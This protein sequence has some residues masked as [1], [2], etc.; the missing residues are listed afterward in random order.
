MQ[1]RSDNA[2]M[3]SLFYMHSMSTG[4]ELSCQKRVRVT[5]KVVGI[6]CLL[7][8]CFLVILNL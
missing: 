1:K 4:V 2:F 8:F 6:G 7:K 3:A 5:V